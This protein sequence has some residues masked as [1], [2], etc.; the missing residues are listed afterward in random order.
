M[1]SLGIAVI[2]ELVKWPMFKVRTTA[3]SSHSSQFVLYF[4]ECLLFYTVQPKT[5][6]DKE[7]SSEVNEIYAH[8]SLVFIYYAQNTNR[9]KLKFLS[10]CES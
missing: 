9:S 7:A 5:A 4:L 3:P 2:S 10:S 8:Y 6:V 1:V